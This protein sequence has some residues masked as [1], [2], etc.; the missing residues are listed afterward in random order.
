M[1]K[2]ELFFKKL[3]TYASAR[4]FACDG[5]KAEL[6]D[7]PAHRLCDDCYNALEFNDIH[8]CQKCGRKSVTEGVCLSCKSVLPTFDKGVSPFVY[9]GTTAAFINR[10]KNGERRLS[11]FFGEQLAKAV[12]VRLPEL[13]TRFDRGRYETNDENTAEK[14]LVVPVPLTKDRQMERGYNQSQE[15]CE[16]L[17]EE[18]NR[19]GVLA[20]TDEEV[21][22]KNRETAL[23]KRLGVISRMENVSGAYR[24][25]KRKL[26]QNRVILLVDDIMT[27]GATG[28]EC[29]RVLKNA[30]AE[31]VY[32]LTSAS[33]P[34]QK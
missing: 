1:N 20:E 15:L 28:N 22:V 31:K 14:L 9:R 27:T 13:K 34:E 25:H 29:A 2:L 7:Y 23:Q 5:C 32:L 4:G 3:R 17:T 26:C 16:V 11:Y 33:L 30:D 12:L 24:V 8:T 18:L 10:M 21:L 6:F 19:L